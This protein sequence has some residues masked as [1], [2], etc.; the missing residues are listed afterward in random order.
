M[1]ATQYQILCRYL[2]ASNNTFVT[3]ETLDK[4]EKVS[5]FYNDLHGIVKG[6]IPE[7][8]AKK[9]RL[10]VE[11]NLS[12]N[13][14]YNMMFKYSGTKR[15]NKKVWITESPNGYVIRDISKIEHLISPPGDFSGNYVIVSGT[16][17]S[18]PNTIVVSKIKP[19]DK[20]II[21][22]NNLLA[23]NKRFYTEQ[24][25][26]SLLEESTM[27]KFK[28]G[29]SLS[30]FGTE[31]RTTTYNGSGS[32]G[33]SYF[34]GPVFIGK[35]STNPEKIIRVSDYGSRTLPANSYFKADEVGDKTQ[36][37][38]FK[39]MY[40]ELNHI[41]TRPIP[42][43]YEETVESPYVISDTYE[44]IETSPWV[45]F[46]NCSSLESALERAKKLVEVLG[47]DNV[48]LIKNVNMDQFVKIQ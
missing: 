45:I 3:N 11:G 35:E 21:I 15:Q 23:K 36:V 2:N 39:N 13:P 24:E 47:I 34:S 32:S 26:R 46:S 37:Y 33:P 8:E 12:S 44:R 43:H 1:A 27:Y 5:E 20:R 19:D 22:S 6:D 40:V 4:Y 29:L 14:N 7:E 48:K 25:A 30:D 9:E 17:L 31:D 28:E 16:D 41:E 38:A 42:P 18:N 10:I